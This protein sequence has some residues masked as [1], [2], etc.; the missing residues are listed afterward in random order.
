MALW[1]WFLVILTAF[2]K[3]TSMTKGHYRQF[4]WHCF[5][6]IWMRVGSQTT[7][8]SEYEIV[9]CTTAN[10][11]CRVVGR[12][13]CSRPQ[14]E[15]LKFVTSSSFR[16]AITE[17]SF[18]SF[19]WAPVLVLPILCLILT[20]RASGND[21]VWRQSFYQRYEL[22]QGELDAASLPCNDHS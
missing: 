21:A 17:F 19:C 3:G 1:N 2:P 9:A 14:A 15:S 7:Q 11:T 22:F 4:C 5:P 6:T 20:S 13:G 18:E 16:Q 8:Y 12:R 10:I